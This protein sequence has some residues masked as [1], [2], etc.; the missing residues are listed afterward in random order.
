MSTTKIPQ[1]DSIEELARFWDQHDLTDFDSELEEVTEP[2]FEREAVVKVRLP[3]KEAEAVKALAQSQGLD[4]A[5]LI[6][7]WI[8]ERIHN[9]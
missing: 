1:T 3:N 2:V 7:R 9:T 4:D 6:R 8:L 5:D